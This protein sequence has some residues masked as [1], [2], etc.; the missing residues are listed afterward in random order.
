MKK[1][2]SAHVVIVGGSTG[3]CAAALAAARMGR[4][5][6]ITEETDWLGGQ[7][8]SQAVPPD[9]H[10]YIEQ[11]GC[12]RGYRRFRDGVRAYYS[13]HFP[14]TARARADSRLPFQIPLGCLIPVR[15]NNVIPACKNIGVTHITNGCYRLH[16]VEWNIGEAAGYLSAFC[17]D[18]GYSPRQV[19][20]DREKLEQ[21]QQMIAREGVEMQWPTSVK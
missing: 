15:M 4:N 7:L 18:K 8:T 1:E 6:I 10:S 16:P 19:R 20:N 3:G 9:E 2:Y 17:L 12:T 14:L 11:F 21:F 5:V 13:H